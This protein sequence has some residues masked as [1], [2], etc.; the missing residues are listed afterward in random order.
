M[1]HERSF[2]PMMTPWYGNWGDHYTRFGKDM[3][4][5]CEWTKRNLLVESSPRRP[6]MWW[7]PPFSHNCSVNL[8]TVYFCSLSARESFGLTVAGITTSSLTSSTD[9]LGLVCYHGFRLLWKTLNLR[10]KRDHDICSA[11]H[12]NLNT[13]EQ[14]EFQHGP[15]NFLNALDLRLTSKDTEKNFWFSF[16]LLTLEAKRL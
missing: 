5:V 4:I 1:W 16:T 13:L 11:S 15:E 6:R 7:Y 8:V 2:K 10:S 9:L 12:I 14:S 3:D